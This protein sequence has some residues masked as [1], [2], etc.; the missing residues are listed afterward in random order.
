MNR[1]KQQVVTAA[2]GTACS[3]SESMMLAGAERGVK[4]KENAE[5]RCATSSRADPGKHWGFERSAGGSGRGGI[6]QTPALACVGHPTAMRAPPATVALLRSPCLPSPWFPLASPAARPPGIF[7]YHPEPHTVF[8]RGDAIQAL[9]QPPKLMGLQTA[10]KHAPL[11]TL[12]I[13]LK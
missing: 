2:P 7:G 5:I 9:A 12:A 8:P 3:S 6:G 10:F 11:Q 1:F 4:P 13:S